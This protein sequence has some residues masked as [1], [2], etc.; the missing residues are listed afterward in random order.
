MSFASPRLWST[1]QSCG[2]QEYNDRLISRGQL[3]ICGKKVKLYKG[4]KQPQVPAGGSAGGVPK[5]ALRKQVTFAV[6]EKSEGGSRS[7]T[8]GHSPRGSVGLQKGQD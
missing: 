3:C 4:K 2:T 8:P 7:S 6:G 1:C 5:S